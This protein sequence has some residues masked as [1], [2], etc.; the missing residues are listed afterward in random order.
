MVSDEG[1]ELE[2][3]Q[4]VDNDDLEKKRIQLQKELELLQ[5]VPS[6]KK[7]L[8]SSSSSTTDGN[9]SSSSAS[10]SPHSDSDDRENDTDSRVKSKWRKRK[11]SP[12]ISSPEAVDQCA[13]ENHRQHRKAVS[14]LKFYRPA[15]SRN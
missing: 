7:K 3:G 14:C 4:T 6:D 5:S 9:S 11:A 10:N 13:K 2:E 8:S 12:M 15:P 1:S